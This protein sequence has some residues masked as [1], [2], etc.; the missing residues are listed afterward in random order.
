MLLIMI[1]CVMLRVMFIEL[2]ELVVLV[3][4]ASSLRFGTSITI[5]FV[6]RRCVKSFEMLVRLF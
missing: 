6:F 4:L 3:N 1:W 2:V 5:S